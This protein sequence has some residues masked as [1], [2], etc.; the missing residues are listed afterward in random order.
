MAVVYENLGN[1]LVVAYS[2]SGK[3]IHGGVPEGDYNFTYFPEETHR[4]YVE[5]DIPVDRPIDKDIHPDIGPT[6]YSK[7]KILLAAQNA[8]FDDT[9]IAFL[10]S[11]RV[12]KYIWDA[13]NVIED[14]EM[15]SQYLPSIA[16]ALNKTEEEV[17]N[18][19]DT[20]CVAD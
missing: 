7:L 9:L 10:E 15:L 8:G 14:N 1:G 3:K 13:S 12:I 19:L 18:F 11:S 4:T 17:R 16:N 20:Y 5:T 6:Q 2:D